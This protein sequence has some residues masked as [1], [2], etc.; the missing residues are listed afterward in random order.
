[1]ELGGV[2]GDIEASSFLEAI[3]QIKFNSPADSLIIHLAPII[4]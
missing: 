1:V 2:A 3:R 4:R